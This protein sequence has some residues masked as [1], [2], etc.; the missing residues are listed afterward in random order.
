MEEEANQFNEPKE[1]SNNNKSRRLKK[2]RLEFCGRAPTAK[3]FAD[4]NTAQEAIINFRILSPLIK[5]RGRKKA[6]AVK[7]EEIRAKCSKESFV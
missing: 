2:T 5:T 4:P 1:N 7:R 6:K 3:T